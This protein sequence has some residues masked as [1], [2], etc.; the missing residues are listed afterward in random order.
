MNIAADPLGLLEPYYATKAAMAQA[1]D[2]MMKQRVDE[3]RKG[4]IDA[5][6]KNV[7]EG[8]D[9]AYFA[10]GKQGNDYAGTLN[11]LAT[12]YL[13]HV[14]DKRLRE[15][16]GDHYKDIRLGKSQMNVLEFEKWVLDAQQ[17]AAD[18]A[19]R[20]GIEAIRHGEIKAVDGKYALA[21]GQYIDKSARAE[22]RVR[23]RSEGINE[24]SPSKIWAINRRIKIDTVS[25]HGI[26]DNRIGHNLYSDTTLARKS[27]DWEQ[28]QRWNTIR[29][30]HTIIVRPTQIGGSYVI[31]RPQV[32]Q[33]PSPQRTKGR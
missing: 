32:P 10:G 13:D 20:D 6:V 23:A 30:G 8:Y 11:K 26:P 25:G 9:R 4:M 31:P 29:P 14:Q 2:A 18:M 1:E 28:I 22:L 19:Y 5:G 15:M 7:P 33:H 24:S 17:R 16:W 3:F 27:S 21:L 12:Q